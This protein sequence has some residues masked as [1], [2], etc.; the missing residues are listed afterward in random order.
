VLSDRNPKNQKNEDL[1]FAPLKAEVGY[2]LQE[3]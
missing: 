1:Y 2:P 3:I